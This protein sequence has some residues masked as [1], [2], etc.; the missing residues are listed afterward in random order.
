MAESRTA[1]AVVLLNGSNV[2]LNG[3][4]YP[5]W[6]IQCERVLMREGLWRIVTGE[7]V[8]STSSASE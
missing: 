4:N 8:A 7:K 5:M 2:L 1:T 6:K 3:S